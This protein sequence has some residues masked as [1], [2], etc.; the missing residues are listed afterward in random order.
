MA[1]NFWIAILAFS[2]SLLAGILI[3]LFTKSRPGEELK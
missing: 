2:T 3:S 1:Q